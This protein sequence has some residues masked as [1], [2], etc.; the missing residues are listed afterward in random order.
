MEVARRLQN[1]AGMKHIK[2]LVPLLLVAFPAVATAAPLTPGSQHNPPVVLDEAS[3]SIDL[4]SAGTNAG[5]KIRSYVEINGFSSKTDTARMDWISKGKVF[6]SIKCD[7]GQ[8]DGYASGECTNSEKAHLVKGPVEVRLI[9]WDD[10]EEKEYLVRTFKLHIHHWK[11][12]W[13]SWQIDA[14][15]ALNTAF[16][17]MGHDKATDS[18]YRNPRLYMWFSGRDNLEQLTL[19]CKVG[20]KKLPDIEIWENNGSGRAVVE[21]VMT[22]AKGEDVVYYWQRK[23]FLINA[24]WGPKATLTE[25]NDP[26]MAD[27]PGQWEC[28]LRNAGKTIRTILFTVDNDGMIQQDEIQSGKNPIPTVSDKVVLVDVRFTKD[29]P[30]YDKRISPAALKKSMQWGLPWPD[31]PKVKEI[32]KS[33]PAKSGLADPPK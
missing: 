3:V 5:Y 12:K 19:R 24:Y 1:A 9:Y 14:D 25:S 20:E 10:Q 2:R 4:Y 7:L 26:V 6:D 22:P 18:T 23:V 11:G 33:Y 27:N 31:H 29:S 13:D 8:D 30:S 17:Y 28:G 16:M 21:S 32:H 15:D